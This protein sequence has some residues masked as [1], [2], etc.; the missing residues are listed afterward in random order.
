MPKSHGHTVRPGFIDTPQGQLYGVL[1]MPADTCVRSRLYI[2]P[3]AEE[4]NRCRSS[5]SVMA[6][7]LAQQGEAVLLL[8]L[9]G[10]GESHGH[11]QDVRLNDWLDDI[12]A[13]ARWLEAESG[14]APA[15]WGMRL[16]ATLAAHAANQHPE[17]FSR[18]LLWQPVAAGKTFITQYLRLRVA[19][20]MARNQPAEDTKGMREALAAGTQL[21]VAGYLLSGPLV[22]DLD[23]LALTACTQL[24]TQRIDW[25]EHQNNPE[26][27][28]NMQSRKVMDNWRTQGCDIHAAGFTG[29][30]LWQSHEIVQVP[31]LIENTLI[32]LDEA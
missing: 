2:P 9:Q 29:A 31:E 32:L 28:L 8:D 21:E 16:G 20:L 24:K 3:F 14:H 4:M 30:Q 7:R 25:I 5:V 6:R 15:L 23:D 19:A 26:K 13:A 10:T 22:E 11:L 18:L 27:P 1:H 17:H 12:M